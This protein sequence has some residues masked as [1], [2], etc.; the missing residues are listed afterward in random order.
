MNEAEKAAKI[1]L[2]V[3]GS[4]AQQLRCAPKL[5]VSYEAHWAYRKKFMRLPLVPRIYLEAAI[6]WQGQNPSLT[7][8]H[9][10]KNIENS[11]FWSSRVSYHHEGIKAI[12]EFILQRSASLD[13]ENIR[14]GVNWEFVLSVNNAC[15]VGL[16]AWLGR[17]YRLT[18]LKFRVSDPLHFC[19]VRRENARDEYREEEA[20]EMLLRAEEIH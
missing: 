14:L 7:Y 12:Q 13:Y 9:S 16:Y 2:W 8:Y 11:R 18:E 17:N 4:R 3:C 19:N 15:D 5:A 20:L 6:Y 10:S 1:I